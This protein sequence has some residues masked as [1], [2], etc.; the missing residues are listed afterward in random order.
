MDVVMPIHSESYLFAR[1]LPVVSGAIPY[2]VKRIPLDFSILSCKC[3]SNHHNRRSGD[4]SHD[5][6][7]VSNG[8]A[9]YFDVLWTGIYPAL[10]L[11]L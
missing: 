10:D 8:A 3:L 5:Q 9:I 1:N 6:L 2:S 4:E 11:D 7:M